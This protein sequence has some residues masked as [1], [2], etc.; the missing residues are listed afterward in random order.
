M[1]KYIYIPM[2]I[3]FVFI[4]PLALYLVLKPMLRHYKLLNGVVNYDSF[5]GKFVFHIALTKEDFYARL[6]IRNIND[7]LEYSLNDDG[8]V[9][10]FT[11][12]NAKFQYKILI[13]EFDEAF[14]LRVEQI[15]KIM[16]KGNVPYYIN[17]F[18]INKFNAKPVE[19]K[20]YSF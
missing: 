9:I 13:D 19:F 17:E 20:K 3:F 11:M 4:I 7:T 16:D 12:Y 8:S 2:I 15:Q 1:E 6:K 18:F 5:M 10:T 14:I